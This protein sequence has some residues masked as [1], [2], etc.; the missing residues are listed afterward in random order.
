MAWERQAG[1]WVPLSADEVVEESPEE[2]TH[3]EPGMLDKEVTPPKT[4]TAV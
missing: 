3:V 2:V 4:G 1:G